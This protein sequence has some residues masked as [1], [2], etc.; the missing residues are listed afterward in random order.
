[1]KAEPPAGITER[2][3]N[4]TTLQVTRVRGGVIAPSPRADV[5]VS[6]EPLEIRLAAGGNSRQL[7][8]TMRTPGSDFEL[9]AGFLFSEGVITHKDEITSIT[10]CVD[11]DLDEEQR[12]NV[13]NVRLR[14]EMLPDLPSLERHFTVN[15]ACGVCGK[16]SIDAVAQGV[17][18]LTAGWTVTPDFISAMSGKLRRA[19]AL[20]DQTGGLHAAALFSRDGALIEVREDV[21]RHNALDKLIGW[22]LL[23]GRL[24]L[25]DYALLVSGRA[26]FELVQKAAM[27]GI[28]LFCAISAP[29][30]LAVALARR[31]SMTLIGFLRSE[32]YNIYA[33][34]ERIC[35]HSAP[36]SP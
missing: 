34:S 19:Q 32:D 30:H 13:V 8:V 33:G 23:N 7:A 18:P 2:P 36:A 35:S 21:G 10:Y 20:F 15:S 1:M 25:S 3:A 24:P 4:K 22:A 16:A 6:E 17:A 27:A 26:S 9:A 28:P 12:Y 31:T 11:R 29:S 5:V 14:T